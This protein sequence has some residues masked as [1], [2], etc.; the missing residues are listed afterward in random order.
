ME[1]IQDSFGG[2]PERGHAA[3]GAGRAT[4]MAH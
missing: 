4:P 3:L 2:N 1:T